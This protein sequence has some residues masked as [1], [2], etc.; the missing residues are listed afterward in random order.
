MLTKQKLPLSA[1]E[2]ILSGFNLDKT[3]SI[4]SLATS[5]NITYLIKTKNKTCL[6]RLCPGGQRWRSKG[7]IAAELELINHLLK[8]NFLFIDIYNCS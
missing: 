7:E 3:R 4:E 8:N 2:K 6:L 5:G 1:I